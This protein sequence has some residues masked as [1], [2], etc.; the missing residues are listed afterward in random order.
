M[1]MVGTPEAD[2]YK[3]RLDAHEMIGEKRSSLAIT[4]KKLLEDNIRVH[5]IKS[6]NKHSKRE[7]KLKMEK[8]YI[9]FKIWRV[10]S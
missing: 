7:T 4:C 9:I 8:G 6:H 2:G 5:G 10:Y 1:C 3:K